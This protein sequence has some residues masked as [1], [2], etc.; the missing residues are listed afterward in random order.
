MYPSLRQRHETQLLRL[1]SM[2]LCN[3]FRTFW[4]AQY[5]AESISHAVH[6]GPMLNPSRIDIPLVHFVPSDFYRFYFLHISFPSVYHTNQCIIQAVY[7]T[8]QWYNTKHDTTCKFRV[9][10]LKESSIKDQLFFSASFTARLNECA[11][12][13]QMCK[14]PVNRIVSLMLALLVLEVLQLSVTT[15]IMFT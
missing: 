5:P 7:H 14:P 13:L 11:K 4:R 15:A 9:P 12:H 3:T 10:P 1:H 8:S 6:F 2:Q